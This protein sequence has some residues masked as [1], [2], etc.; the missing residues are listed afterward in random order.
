[1]SRF[2]LQSNQISFFGQKI[3]HYAELKP[4]PELKPNCCW[5][6]KGCIEIKFP[7]LAYEWTCDFWWQ[8]ANKSWI[9]IS[10]NLKQLSYFV[11]PQ[12]F[13]LKKVLYEF[14]QQTIFF[15]NWSPV[16]KWNVKLKPGA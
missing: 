4:G 16:W 2:I 1:M 12:N 7:A 13:S 6:L 8:L 3:P 10:Q 5:N 11:G 9:K 15:G 14:L